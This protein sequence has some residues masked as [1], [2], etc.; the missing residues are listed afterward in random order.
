MISME[1]FV[2]FCIFLQ[3]FI[4]LFAVEAFFFHQRSNNLAIS[5]IAIFREA[6]DVAVKLNKSQYQS[7]RIDLALH[8][9]EVHLIIVASDF[10]LRTACAC[11]QRQEGDTK[12]REKNIVLSLFS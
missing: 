9:W 8:L 2:I 5:R 6:S 10:V 7:E 11:V 4:Y 12:W 3:L 1:T